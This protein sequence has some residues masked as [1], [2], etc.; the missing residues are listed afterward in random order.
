V[1][2][3]RRGFTLIEILIAMSIIAVLASLLFL[4][5]HHVSG[6]ARG[7]TT[8]VT[9]QTL[10]GMLTEF[11]QAGGRVAN[12]DGIY[13]DFPYAQLPSMV[14]PPPPTGAYPP[15]LVKEGGAARFGE[16][17]IRTQ[18]VMRR[19]AAIPAVK[20]VMDNQHGDVQMLVEFQ[21]GVKYQPGDELIVPKGGG[22]HDNFVCTAPN[23]TTAPPGAG[24]AATDRHTPV[25][26]DGDRS[27]IIFVPSNG[28][29]F[30][31]LGDLGVV[32]PTTQQEKYTSKNATILAPG[33]KPNPPGTP[34]LLGVRPFFASAG[35]DGDF[36][37][38][39]DNHYSFEQ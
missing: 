6:S 17:T 26:V 13:A 7:N 15:T 31:N 10:R 33:A 5:F 28:L 29:S 12:L 25:L 23:T 9:L 24:W 16:A 19:L 39:D 34:P 30:V 27:P 4:A 1:R 3:D 11:E 37:K 35:T 20:S 22:Q 38:G 32:D 36:N 2:R 8:A 21:S 14:P 18:R